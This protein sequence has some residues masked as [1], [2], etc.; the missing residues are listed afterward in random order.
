MTRK[1]VEA[2][3]WL[4]QA[5][6]DREFALFALG[7]ARYSHVCLLCQQAAEKAVKSLY[8]ARGLTFPLSHLISEMCRALKINGKLKLAA[9]V[10][11]QY[12]VTARY[13][14]GGSSLAPFE[15]FQRQ[16]ATEALEYSLLFI[17]AAQRSSAAKRKRR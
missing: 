17:K 10:L 5:V 11:D 16:Q 6:D 9:A 13:P 8:L 2:Q 3:A 12:Y 14:I 15:L 1:K 4:R 7:D